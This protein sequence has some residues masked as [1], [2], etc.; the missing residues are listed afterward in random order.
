MVSNLYATGH[1]IG[2]DLFFNYG[3]LAF[4]EFPEC[5]N[6]NIFLGTIV[7]LLVKLFLIL[8]IVYLMFSLHHKDNPL[9]LLFMY[10]PVGILL[11][12]QNYYG[13]YFG[14]LLIFIV[15][16]LLLIHSI[17][18]KKNLYLY[19]AI[20]IT[21]LTGLIKPAFTY[22]AL[23]IFFSYYIC[24]FYQRRKVIQPYK[25]FLFLALPYFSI[26][27]LMIGSFKTF[28]MYLKATIELTIGNSDTM[29]YGFLHNKLFFVLSII[30]PV[31]GI[32]LTLKKRIAS[33]F[34]IIFLPAILLWLKYVLA[35]VD[36][37]F[38]EFFQLYFYFLFMPLLFQKDLKKYLLYFSVILLS[39]ECMN[40]Y[41]TN[42]TVY[43]PRQSKT[44]VSDIFLNNIKANLIPGNIFNCDNIVKFNNKFST[45]T[46]N[47]LKFS[48]KVLQEI[49]N[50]TV[51]CYPFDM[52]SIF[53]NGLNWDPRPLFQSYIA[54]TPWLDL[55]NQKFFLSAKK[56]PEYL[57]WE[58]MVT[59]KL[60]YSNKID[61]GYL[62]NDSSI[63]N[64]YLLNDEP[65]TIKAIFSN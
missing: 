32:I 43:N 58:K 42:M 11:I 48:P 62:L 65:L 39:F 50:Q 27:Y 55:Q 19:L 22:L 17:Y 23:I 8:T 2:K 40:I 59:D 12:C 38:Y 14:Y 53:A 63:D 16:N 5:I 25:I 35:R 15:I 51:D 13:I 26:W 41:S 60:Q 49:K 18:P 54:Y 45:E 7:Y 21:S 4:V 52:V 30:L 37:I 28:P 34:L 36:H 10:I 29:I 9:K 33:I 47:L 31:L 64:R 46:L 56:A 3:P 1:I 6:N 20:G 44:F 57:I 24:L 61:Y